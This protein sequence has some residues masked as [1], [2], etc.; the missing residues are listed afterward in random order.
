MVFVFRKILPT[1]TPV[2][3]HFTKNTRVI[4]LY[5]QNKN[6]NEDL[7]A[8]GVNR[9]ARKQSGIRDFR[10]KVPYKNVEVA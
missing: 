3:Y 10:A 1:S 4:R 7:R 5:A 9:K 8:T 6:K 2:P